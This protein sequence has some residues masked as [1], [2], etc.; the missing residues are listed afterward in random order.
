VAL[1]LDIFGYLSVL[2]RGLLLTAQSLT[3]GSLAFLLLLLR[4]LSSYLSGDCLAIAARCQLVLRIGAFAFAALA[5]C[6]LFLNAAALVGTVEVSWQDALNAGFARA[7]FVTA[8]CACLIGLA[9]R[10]KWNLARCALLATLAVVILVAQLTTTHAASRLDGRWPFLIGDAL[11]MIGAGIWIGGLPCFLIALSQ[12]DNGTDWR[13]IGRR[14][15]L[16]S[17]SSVAAILLGGIVMSYGY[18]GSVEALYG[19]SYG[20]M[21]LTKVALFLLLLM[22]G[23]GNFFTVDTLRHDS[24]TSI[25]RLK[26]FAEAEIGIGMTVLFAAASLT[27]LPPGADLKED[28][29]NWQEIAERVAPQWPIRLTSP[30]HDELYIP[31]LQARIAAADAQK[32][33]A[34]RAYVP[35]EGLVAPRNAADVAW[36]EYNHHW[37]GVFVLLIGFLALIEHFRWGRFARHWPLLFLGMAAFLFFRSDPEAWPMGEIGFLASMRDPEVTQHRIFV[38]LIILFGL[39]EWRVRL[40][41]KK[42]SRAALVFPLTTAIGGA[43]LLTHSHAVANVKE[44]MLIEI[45]HVSIAIFGVIGGWARWLELRLEGTPSRIASWIWPLAFIAVGLTLLDYREA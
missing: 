4:P 12:C 10:G 33:A 11:H 8:I 40:S 28:R 38:L 27:S 1:L 41:D 43:M 19:T 32:T 18:I 23:A 45:S 13:L 22:L 29:V 7:G 34:P 3:F 25:L 14:Y 39:F 42:D 44:E 5:L 36:S 9:S 17:M 35:G 21:T 37:A 16:M 15:S 31:M 2:L 30:D 20:V 24:G 26:R 6:A